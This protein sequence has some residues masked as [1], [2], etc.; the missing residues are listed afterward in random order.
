M[1]RLRMVNEHTRF[2]RIAF[3]LLGLLALA[4]PTHA[5]QQGCG[6]WVK[7]SI[8]PESWVQSEEKQNCGPQGATQNEVVVKK[9]ENLG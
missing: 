1:K 6:D 5:Q 3:A 8:S 7:Q 2:A 4:V 9:V